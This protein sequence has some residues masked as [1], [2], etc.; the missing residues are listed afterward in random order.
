MEGVGS[1]EGSSSSKGKRE[2]EHLKTGEIHE[3]IE[4]EEREF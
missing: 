4:W 2:R 3:G 1:V